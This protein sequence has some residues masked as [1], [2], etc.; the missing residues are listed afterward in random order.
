MSREVITVYGAAS[1]KY[2]LKKCRLIQHID[3]KRIKK[4]PEDYASSFWELCDICRE[5]HRVKRESPVGN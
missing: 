1:D 2:H 5:N 3:E 4:R